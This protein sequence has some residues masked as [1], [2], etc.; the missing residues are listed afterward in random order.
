MSQVA[1]VN[2]VKRLNDV[3]F[4]L[5]KIEMFDSFDNAIA[6]L[7]PFLSTKELIDPRTLTIEFNGSC[8]FTIQGTQYHSTKFGLTSLCKLFKIPDPF[9]RLI[10]VELLKTNIDR[11]A[12]EYKKEIQAVFD[13][14]QNI[15]GFTAAKYRPIQHIDLLP[16]LKD[17]F[18][19]S[20]NLVIAVS[21]RNVLV[22]FTSPAFPT[23]TVREG[24][25]I[26]AGL[27]IVNSEVNDWDAKAQIF[28]LRTKDNAGALM[29]ES[30]GKIS[31]NKNN[32]L[33][34]ETV[35]DQFVSGCVEFETDMV[36]L[37]AVFEKL[38]N[39]SLNTR[40]FS[41]VYGALTHIAG[42]SVAEQVLSTDEA[43]AKD[44]IQFEKRRNKWNIR[45]AEWYGKPPKDTEKNALSVFDRLLDAANG[46]TD[47]VYCRK[48][49]AIVGK[50]IAALTIEG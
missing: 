43:E 7:T 50:L 22:Q 2:E 31:R 6:G 44:F 18:A 36:K 45:Y 16:R 15:I 28:M 40:H 23:F 42:K 46:S 3:G 29:T 47:L 8:T 17:K 32:K 37:A 24:E 26:K 35:V 12:K 48:M 21:T 13:R 9:S 27:E 41:V 33:Q 19:G 10:P 30:W 25:F 11:L 39:I 4:V 34:Y 38:P 1:E 20:E 14:N 49:R 5:E